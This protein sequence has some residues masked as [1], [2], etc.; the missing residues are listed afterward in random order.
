MTGPPAAP[1]T[2]SPGLWAVVP[3]KPFA[4]AKSR[5]GTVLTGEE[6]SLLAQRLLQRTIEVLLRVEGLGRIAVVSRDEA[7]LRLARG[8]GVEALPE[9]G[10]GL[11]PALAYAA[12]HAVQ[13]GATSL[14]VLPA[15]LP[16]LSPSDVLAVL[17]AG[18]AAAVTIAHDR[19]HSGT[20]ALLLRPPDAVPFAFGRDSFNLHLAL[21]R[22]AGIEPAVV[23]RPGLAFDVDYPGDLDDLEVQMPQEW[24]DRLPVQAP[25]G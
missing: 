22:R 19:H 7:A 9:Q 1:A 13:Y 18:Q 2:P 11:N 15:D 5:L 10:E 23:S 24:L 14:L 20:N 12:A 21:A 25:E 17:E 16:M 8:F 6:R 3:A 4:E